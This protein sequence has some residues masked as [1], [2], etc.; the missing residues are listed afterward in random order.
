[1]RRF[2]RKALWLSLASTLLAVVGFQGVSYAETASYTWNTTF[3]GDPVAPN[4]T[5]VGTALRYDFSSG[6]C[7]MFAGARFEVSITTSQLLWTGVMQ[8][9]HT[10]SADIWH[11]RFRFID[12]NDAT[13][14]TSPVIDG[15][16][17]TGANVHYI[18][19]IVMP[20]TPM[21]STLI[22]STQVEWRGDC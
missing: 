1:M 11:A 15:P 16:R 19:R 21:T 17:M 14:Y 2:S 6:D 20:I 10:D 4:S 8:T 13:L 5:I 9:S 12:K 7:T 18:F 3:L 22:Y